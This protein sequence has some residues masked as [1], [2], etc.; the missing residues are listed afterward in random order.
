MS[1]T[2]FTLKVVPLLLCAVA[3]LIVIWLWYSSTPAIAEDIAVSAERYREEGYVNYLNAHGWNGQLA[4]TAI[5]LLS[6]TNGVSS[7][8]ISGESL[9]WDFECLN[10]G[11]YNLLVEY[12]P[13]PG[14]GAQLERRLFLDGKLP[15]EGMKQ[16]VFNRSYDNS[17]GGKAIPIKNGSEIRQR[18]SEVFEWTE[19]YISDSQKRN[20]DPY[21]LYLSQG[22][23][24]LS[25]ESVKG[26]ML[27]RRLEFRAADS[28]LPWS[29]TK[30]PSTNKYTGGSIT[31][32]AER[33][34]GGTVRV[35]KSSL[36]IRNETDYSSVDT[37][38]YHPWQT[39]LNVIGGSSWRAPANQLHGRLR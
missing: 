25:L 38:P 22:R 1:K 36:S 35:L 8:Q 19:I 26:A 2:G 33:V 31:F 7:G 23:H 32:Q 34:E 37:V 9:S 6:T 27:I 5:S 15:Y 12:V 3:L 24:T 29:E 4:S 17:G 28:I 13:L 39:R 11:F 14:S 21:M 20:T 30:F 18:S 16:L 10:A